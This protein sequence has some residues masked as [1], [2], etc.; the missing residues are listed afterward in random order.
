MH[1]VTEVEVTYDATDIESNRPLDITE[2]NVSS[3]MY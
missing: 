2:T 3:V 1:T